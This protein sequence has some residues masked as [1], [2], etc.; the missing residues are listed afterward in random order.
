MLSVL[1]YK[2]S[3]QKKNKTVNSIQLLAAID[4]IIE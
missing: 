4:I 3:G 1:V 2:T